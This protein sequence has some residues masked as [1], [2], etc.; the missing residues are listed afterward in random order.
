MVDYENPWTY[1]ER[2]FTS[3]DVLDNF[4]FVGR[5]ERQKERNERSNKKVI[6]SGI[7]DHVQN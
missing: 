3:D 5:L 6:G 4:G 2:P 1:L 7:T